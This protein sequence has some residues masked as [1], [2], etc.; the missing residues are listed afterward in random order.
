MNDQIIV[1]TKYNPYPV[2][3][4]YINEI[5]FDCPVLLVSSKS[6][7]KIYL[8][9]MLKLIK[10]KNISS[11]I[12]GDGEEFKT[13]DSILEI[14]DCAFKAK[15]DRKS[16]MISL[17]GGVI[18]DLVGFASGIYLRGIDF[19]S[20]PTTLLA[21]V[22]ASVGGKCGINNNYGKNLVGLF[23]QP[24]KVLVDSTFLRSL[25]D[26][27]YRAGFSEIIKIFACFDYSVLENFNANNVNEYI[28]YAIFLKSQVVEADE[29]EKSGVRALLNYGHTFAHAIELET[30]FKEYLHGEAVSMGIVMANELSLRLGLIT[31][32]KSDLIESLF[33]IM[34][35]PTRY[36]I[37]N[38]QNFFNSFYLDKKSVDSKLHF[39]LLNQNGVEM[40]SDISK[41]DILATLSIFNLD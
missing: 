15:L 30:N 6:V 5:E 22:D 19:I 9:S 28:K 37:K 40:K 32:E 14:L 41:D 34:K 39:I 29:N 38:K 16:V 18:S 31:Q 8:D 23:H 3:L 13:M 4:G 12:I 35:L 11:C 24:K 10:A 27:E 21:M 33:N 20:I 26:R 36:K 17:G 25:P 2:V 1:N 7:A